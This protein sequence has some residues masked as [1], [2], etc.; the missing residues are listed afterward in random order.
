MHLMLHQIPDAPDAS[1]KC[2]SKLQSVAGYRMEY[3]KG[4]MD[5]CWVDRWV[6]VGWILDVG[7]MD[8]R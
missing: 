7:W 4:W 1:T 5:G 2:C 6:D 8:G 3:Q